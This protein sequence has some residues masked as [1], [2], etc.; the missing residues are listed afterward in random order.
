VV[1]ALIITLILTDLT[2]T[3]M[4]MDLHTITLE[5]VH[6]NILRPV[7]ARVRPNSGR[8]LTTYLFFSSPVSAGDMLGLINNVMHSKKASSNFRMIHI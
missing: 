2:T 6:R 1:E 4:T 5:V 8:S 3:P 7:E